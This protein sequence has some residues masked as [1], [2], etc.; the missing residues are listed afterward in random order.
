MWRE[1]YNIFPFVVATH[2]ASFVGIFTKHWF[3]SRV[4]QK[5]EPAEILRLELQEG[6]N[7]FFIIL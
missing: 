6:S 3:I 4:V 2:A 7:V 5:Y 1:I